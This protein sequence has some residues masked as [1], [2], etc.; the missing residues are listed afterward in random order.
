VTRFLVALTTPYPQRHANTL[1]RDHTAYGGTDCGSRQPVA[2]ELAV[3][4]LSAK[5]NAKSSPKGLLF[6]GAGLFT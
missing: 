3:A 4:K 5:R 1:I 6:Y 2:E